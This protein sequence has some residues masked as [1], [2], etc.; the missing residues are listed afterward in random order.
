MPAAA[1]A[2]DDRD[3]S[4][5][6]RPSLAAFND[7]GLSDRQIASYY[8]VS[9]DKVA[10]LRAAYGIADRSRPVASDP[11]RRRRFHWRRSA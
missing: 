5:I 2:L 6:D 3:A 11:P 1:Q 7:L 10:M 8:K 9:Q 4:P